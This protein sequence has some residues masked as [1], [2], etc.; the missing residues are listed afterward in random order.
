VRLAERALRRGAMDETLIGY[1]G[2]GL[3]ILL[4]VVLVV[5][6]LGFF[7]VET[8]RSSCPGPPSRRKQR[9]ESSWGRLICRAFRGS[10]AAAKLTS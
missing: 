3:R 1:I 10:S 9:R 5:A 4:D 8:T 7:G 2:S 6:I